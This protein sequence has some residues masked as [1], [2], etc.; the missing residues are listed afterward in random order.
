[1]PDHMHVFAA[2]AA[3]DSNLLK[4][5]ASFKQDTGA[6]YSAR[7]GKRLWQFK[8]YD[9]ILRASDAADRVAQYVWM[10]PVRK[11][12]CREPTEYKFLGSFTDI[13]NRMLKGTAV[14]EWVPQWK[15]P[16]MPR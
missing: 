6:R 4:F 2:G 15:K 8:Y 3:D 14:P 7:T 10:N 12:I 5:V 13:G 9:H 11:G 1:M 16:F